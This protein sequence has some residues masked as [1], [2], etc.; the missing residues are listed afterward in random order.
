[1]H[2]NVEISDISMQTQRETYQL[3]IILIILR[4]WTFQVNIS[5]I[6]DSFLLYSC[7]Y[8]NW[9]QENKPKSI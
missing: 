5:Y 1:M 9:N 2:V 6:Q 3:L 8:H 4:Q 7:G